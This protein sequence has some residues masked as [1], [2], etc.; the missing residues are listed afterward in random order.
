MVAVN[1]EHNGVLPSIYFD[2]T[3]RYSSRRT[4]KNDLNRL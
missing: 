1:D 4:L 3:A 2:C